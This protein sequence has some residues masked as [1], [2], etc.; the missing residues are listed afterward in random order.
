M[1]NIK[2]EKITLIVSAENCDDI[3]GRVLDAIGTE[4]GFPYVKIIDSDSQDLEL[5]TKL[6][7][8]ELPHPELA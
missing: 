6:K 8:L 3:L 2:F 4:N 1:T 5:T 7:T